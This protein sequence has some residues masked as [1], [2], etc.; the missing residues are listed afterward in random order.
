MRNIIRNHVK[1][2]GLGMALRVGTSSLAGL[3]VV[4]KEHGHI[5]V[6]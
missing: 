3:E 4:M 6:G 5:R 2:V 1:H